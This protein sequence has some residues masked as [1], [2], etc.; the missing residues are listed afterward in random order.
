MNLPAV[1]VA[2]SLAG[3]AAPGVANMAIQ[4]LIAQKRASNFSEA[5]YGA[6]A[7]SANNE[8]KKSLKGNPPDFCSLD[9]P[10]P[11]P[12]VVAFTVTCKVG[13]GQFEQTAARSFR[14]QSQQSTYTNPSR[15]FAWETP[16]EYS[17]V[18]CLATDP[19]GVMWYNSHLAAGGLKQCIPTAAW[20]RNR[21]FASNPDDWLWDISGHGYGQHPDY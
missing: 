21:Y 4:P 1:L 18:E 13:E 5:E 7:Y 15:Q 19:W 3:I 6:V 8:G 2:A 16:A 12:N 20:N 9:P 11:A 10:L 17:H 14:L